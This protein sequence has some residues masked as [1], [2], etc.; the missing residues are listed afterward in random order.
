MPNHFSALKRARQ[1]K[2]RTAVNRMNK[3]AFRA[4][5]RN[6]RKSLD[7]GPRDQAAPLVPLT[8]SSIDKAVQKGLI[9]KNTAARL[10]SRLMARWNA[11]APAAS[12]P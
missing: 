11:A 5:L 8:L 10:K 4:R 7:S 6:V 3:G 9:H 1:T 2:K 12:H